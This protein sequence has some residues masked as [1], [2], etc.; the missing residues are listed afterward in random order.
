MAANRDLVTRAYESIG[1]T[2]IGSSPSQIDQDGFDY[3]VNQL[4]SNLIAPQD[5]NRVFGSAVDEYM[6]E[7]QND[8]VEDYVADYLVRSAYGDIGRSGIG[9]DVGQID[10]SGYDY[11][12][13]E[14]KSGDTAPSDLGRVFSSSVNEYIEQKP[15]DPYTGYVVKQLQSRTPATGDYGNYL[16]GKSAVFATPGTPGTYRQTRQP[17]LESPMMGAGDANYQSPL[18]QAL[19]NS[20]SNPFSSNEGVTKY[21]YRPGTPGAARATNSSTGNAANNP[22]DFVL[23]AAS[24]NDVADW[25]NYNTYR[26]NSLQ[27]KTPYTSFQE[28]LAGGKVS[29]VPDVVIPE[30]WMYGANDGGGA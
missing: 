5:F 11:W 17:G 10:K 3:W 14:L 19:R 8:P 21:D 9:A 29:G 28:W 4:D 20:S 7:K 18:I 26:T 13:D 16:G 15:N 23:D 27:A 2:D 1:R 24:A 22:Q 12:I 25:N 30:T 6:L